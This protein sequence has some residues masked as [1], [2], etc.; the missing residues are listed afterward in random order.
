MIIKCFVCSM[1]MSNCYVVHNDDSKEC[2]IIDPGAPSKQLED[3]LKKNELQPKYVIITH[4]HGDHT[5]GF[6]RLKE[7]YPDIKLIACKKEAKLLYDRSLSMGRGGYVADIEVSDNDISNL[8][9]INLMFIETP[10]HTPGGMC[11]YIGSEKVLFSGDTLFQYSIGRTDFWG[12]DFD[13]IENS[14]MNK[15]YKLPDDTRVLCGH[16]GETTIGKEK[17]YN[18]FVSVL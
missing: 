5:D 9:G 12:G 3:Y 8:C 4:G 1:Y 16:M 15:L 17:K 7:L 6:P 11:I 13:Q 2:F 14:I 18:P 10:G